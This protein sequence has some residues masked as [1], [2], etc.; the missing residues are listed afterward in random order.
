MYAFLNTSAWPSVEQVR[1]FWEGWFA[2]YED[3]KKPRL[4][5]RFRSRN[6]HTHLSAFLELF[7][8]ALLKRAGYDV[9][10]DPP[11]GSRHLEFLAS[12]SARGLTFY[13]ECTAVAR[14]KKEASADAREAPL[15]EAIRKVWT[16]PFFLV[17]HFI[18]RGPGSPP[19]KSLQQGLLAWCS[20]LETDQARGP[21]PANQWTWENH[22]WTI[23]FSAVMDDEAGLGRIRI[24][25]AREHLGRLRVALDEKASKYGTLSKPLLVVIGSTEHHTEHDLMTALVGEALPQVNMA[26]RDVSVRRKPTGVFYDSKR[27]R[28]RALSAVMYGHFGALSFADKPIILVHHPFASHP[29]PL[30]LFPFCEERHFNETGDLVTAAARASVGAFFDLSPGWPF[31]DLDLSRYRGSR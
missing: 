25:D 18:K 29:L 4:A 7:A 10:S 27:P 26:T 23:R 1:Q 19:T 13:T 14:K 5:A 11:V 2:K 9:E 3:N 30:G 24:F 31:L 12:M 16:L 22:G 21:Q 28:N 17:V 6:D 15:L 8:F 20:S